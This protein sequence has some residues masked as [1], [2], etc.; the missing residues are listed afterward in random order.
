MADN[1]DTRTQK[2]KM[3]DTR[4]LEFQTILGQ[5]VVAHEGLSPFQTPFRI[6]SDKM[7]EWNTIHGFSINKNVIPPKGRENFIYLQKQEDVLPAVIA[8]FKNYAV[9]PKKYGLPENP[10][11]EDAI[12]TF[13]QTGAKGKLAFLKKNNIDIK[14]RL[15][16][17]F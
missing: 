9:N 1:I 16:E 14:T 17:L 10:T 4:K 6:T 5:N 15:K 11:I 12:R 7:R 13:D 2:Q 3:I 8:Q